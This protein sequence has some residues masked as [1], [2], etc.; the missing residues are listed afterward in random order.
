MPPE[1]ICTAPFPL[2]HM[3]FRQ[4][5]R[6]GAVESQYLREHFQRAIV[7]SLFRSTTA[8]AAPVTL[9]TVLRNPVVR[10]Q[11]KRV[12]VALQELCDGLT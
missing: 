10:L 1:A 2:S 4:V 3:L 11:K 6:S 8:G 12:V 9:H 7:L 5:R